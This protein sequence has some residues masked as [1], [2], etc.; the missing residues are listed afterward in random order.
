MSFSENLQYN[1]TIAGILEGD[2]TKGDSV[3]GAFTDWV[4]DWRTPDSG[5]TKDSITYYDSLLND[6]KIAFDT[7]GNQ[8]VGEPN[9]YAKTWWKIKKRKYEHI[10]LFAIVVEFLSKLG[11]C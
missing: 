10:F 8:T 5:F 4:T 7:E 11:L 2:T 9:D 1:K 6:G 3:V